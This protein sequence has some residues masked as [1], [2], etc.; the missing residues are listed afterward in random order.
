MIFYLLSKSKNQFLVLKWAALN[1]MLWGNNWICCKGRGPRAITRPL[2]HD[3]HIKSRNKH[4]LLFLTLLCYPTSD[5]RLQY[6]IRK[7]MKRALKWC[8]KIENRTM[9]NETA[10]KIVSR[11]S[12][13]DFLCESCGGGW[14]NTDSVFS[15]FHAAKGRIWVL[16]LRTR[17]GALGRV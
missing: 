15:L 1:R 9:D 16:I 7:L 4:D 5:F 10:V 14:R 11:E 2:P 13:R 3:S 6:A 8:I 12:F 17:K